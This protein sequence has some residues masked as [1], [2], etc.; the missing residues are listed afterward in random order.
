MVIF[1]SDE[2]TFP[3]LFVA[4]ESLFSYVLSSSLSHF[5]VSRIVKMASPI[6]SEVVYVQNRYFT[7]SFQLVTPSSSSLELVLTSMNLF[8]FPFRRYGKS[9]QACHSET[10]KVSNSRHNSSK[11]VSTLMGSSPSYFLSLSVSYSL[12]TRSLIFPFLFQYAF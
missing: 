12:L 7:A 3:Q 9:I 2:W 8:S 6:A 1:S 4:V 5:R 11:N 10:S